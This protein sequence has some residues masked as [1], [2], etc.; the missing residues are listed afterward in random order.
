[1]RRC[2]WGAVLVEEI[3]GKERSDV[4]RGCVCGKP[5]KTCDISS[6]FEGHL[7]LY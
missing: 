2:L 5:A 4:D 3:E 6:H 1:M 7:Q